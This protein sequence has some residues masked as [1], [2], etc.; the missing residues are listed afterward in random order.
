MKSIP[1][2]QH[3]KTGVFIDA[4]N[5]FWSMRANYSV[6]L[7]K[8]KEFLKERHSPVFYNYY[9]CENRRPDA[10][11][12][13]QAKKQSML[14][15]YLERIGYTV[16]RK[17]LKHIGDITKCDMDVDIVMDMHALAS[18][19]DCIAL[20]SGDSDFLLALKAFL[21]LGKSIKIYSF[22]KFLAWELKEFVRRQH[23][24]SYDVLDKYRAALQYT[25]T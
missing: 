14:L 20:V 12:I 24:C 17:D 8:F 22:K 15:A 7:K 5:L 10:S 25:R 16:V 9:A 21:A 6:D 19:Y 2:P 18:E 11:Y 1:E 13:A 3:V 4:S 23:R